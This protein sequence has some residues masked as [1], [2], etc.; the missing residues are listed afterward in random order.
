M[1]VGFS[2]SKSDM[3]LFV[4]HSTLGT[5]YLLLYVD[6]IIFT[7]SSMVLLEHFI[8]I[9]ALNSEFAMTDMGD[10]HYFLGIAIS[11]TS[12]GR[13]RCRDIGSCRHELLHTFI[14]PH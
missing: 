14:D 7:A 9:K 2:C 12:S 6:D 10:L 3:S 5:A 8:F 4:L 13:V 1:M 11:R